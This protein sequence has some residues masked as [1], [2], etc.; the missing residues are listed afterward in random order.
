MT[1]NWEIILDYL[2]RVGII[3]GLL[4]RSREG[5]ETMK[6]N[7]QEPE[8]LTALEIW[9]PLLKRNITTSA[10]K[11]PPTLLRQSLWLRIKVQVRTLFQ[12]NRLYFHLDFGPALFMDHNTATWIFQ[13]VFSIFS[14]ILPFNGVSLS[15]NLIITFWKEAL[16][17]KRK[18]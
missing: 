14:C 5:E 3:T 7:N 10:R 18:L 13:S 16:F 6:A 2:G 12:T 15:L 17:P 9:A 11:M 1:L 8:N 4:K